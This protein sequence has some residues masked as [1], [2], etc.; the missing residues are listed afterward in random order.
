MKLS[1][2]ER[3]VVKSQEFETITYG[4]DTRNLPLLFQ[5]LRTNLYADLYGSIIR[6]LV[7][8]VVDSHTEANKP[9]TLGEVEWVDENRGLG[10]DCALI[11]R[12]FGVGLSPERMSTVYGNYL[13][14]TKRDAN[15]QIG[16]FGLGSKVPF[17]YTDSFFV[18]TVYNGVRTKYL[19][20]IDK[21][22]LGAISILE[23]KETD[24]ENQTEIV[25]PIKSREDKNLFSAAINKQLAYF[26]TI[27]Y[28]NI[29][30]PDNEILF[31]NDVCIILDNPPINEVH[32]VSGTVAYD[33]SFKELGLDIGHSSWSDPHFVKSCGVGLKFAIG[34]LQ[35]T[36][37]RE[38][39]FWSPATKKLVE[40]RLDQARKS[41]AKELT[42][43]ISSEKDYAKWQG[44][45]STGAT[46]RF[47]KQ[48]K[49]AKME[50]VTKF[51]STSGML[52][53]VTMDQWFQDYS[54]RVVTHPSKTS[55]RRSRTT[56]T[57]SDYIVNIADDDD[58][59]KPAF[60]LTDKLNAKTCTWLFKQY[61]DGFIVVKYAPGTDDKGKPAP[62]NTIYTKATGKWVQTLQDFETL[63]VPFEQVTTNFELAEAARREELK[64]RKIE[65]RYV[66]KKLYR[67]EGVGRGIV[68][69]FTYS[70]YNGKFENDK[71]I[72]I[73]YGFQEDHEKLCKVAAFMDNSKA[74]HKKWETAFHS[75]SYTG[76]DRVL[77]L[78]ISKEH[79]KT[80]AFMPDAHYVDNVLA[81]TT[82][83]NLELSKVTTAYRL[84][85]FIH[86]FHILACFKDIN[87]DMK[88]KY[89]KLHQFIEDY[90]RPVVYDSKTMED[91]VQLNMGNLYAPMEEI[92]KE[93]NQ[94]FKGV[95]MLSTVNFGMYSTEHTG[96][97]GYGTPVEE[98]TGTIV[99]Y[100][101]KY[102]GQNTEAI[103]HYLKANG[104]AID[105]E[106]GKPGSLVPQSITP[107]E[108]TMVQ[109]NLVFATLE[110]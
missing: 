54:V 36:L 106:P 94:Y 63:P 40:K 13:S 11:V 5:M 37:S 53:Y 10:I 71:D 7:S 25:I 55:T 81:L 17:A 32:I 38:G 50:S 83:L 27:K 102:V 89:V 8:N 85:P 99:S 61:P 4:V 79:S 18:Q 86:V 28:I 70:M 20:Y 6:E 74:I 12:D 1:T 47:P 29:E 59:F 23:Q 60:R 109:D 88:N 15:D 65:G 39:L 24:S 67:G 72:T 45:V 80:F 100:L 46:A 9:A 2:E 30:E 58:L 69:S 52:D 103:K 92:W 84:K 75:S 41:I 43:E 26:R 33:I 96:S 3:D 57:N 82:S 21:T 91:M 76:K 19:C 77:F 78:K 90:A 35:P 105:S 101:K 104:K 68:G 51:K 22:Q 87:N 44:M 49:F 64:L 95:E 34:E 110:E 42:S 66:A 93:I 48:W 56:L 14:S 97:S 107:A 98:G 62:K 16:G 73:V 31:E 108:I